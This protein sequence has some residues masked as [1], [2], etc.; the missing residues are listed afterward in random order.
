MLS[1][2]VKITDLNVEQWR[3]LT[4]LV[5]APEK[6]RKIL[7]M[8]E[9]GKALKCWDTVL[10]EL[11]LPDL[12]L[13]DLQAAADALREKH[14]EAYEVWVLEPGSFAKKM[15]EIQA[16]AKFETQQDVYALFEFEER[17]QAP[18]FAMAPRRDFFWHG[19]PLLRVQKFVEK[20]LPDSCVFVLGVFDGDLLWASLLVE[21]ENKKIVSISTSDSLPAEDIKDVV[22]RDQHPYF[23]SLAANALHRPAFGWFVEREA[24][25]A[26]MRASDLE[27]KNEIFQKALMQNQATFDFNIL[28]DRGITAFSPMDPGSAAIQG[29]DREANPRIQTPDPDDSGPSAF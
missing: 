20:M 22:G 2:S 1:Q 6:S 27:T 4:E 18:G 25:E 19:A 11:A 10:G 15:A 7:L 3:R 28:V 13:T 12:N 17:L 21:F 16:Q 26:Y 9:G 14:P 23:L 8:H 24:F 5:Y 29:Q